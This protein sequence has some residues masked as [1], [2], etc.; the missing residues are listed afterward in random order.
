MKKTICNPSN[1]GAET[2]ISL[3]AQSH[4]DAYGRVSNKFIETLLGEQFGYQVVPAMKFL[5]DNAEPS[6][7]A[8]FVG[9]Y[10]TP[11]SLTSRSKA[12]VVV[13]QTPDKVKRTGNMG[14]YA[15]FIRHHDGEEQLVR[16][17]NQAS[18]IYYLMYLIDRRQNTG[19][20]DALS[21]HRNETPFK[22]LYRMVYDRVND[23]VLDC[24]YQSLLRRK[25]DNHYR[26]GRQNAIILDIRKH[27]GQLFAACGENYQPFAMTAHTHLSITPDHIVFDGDADRLLDLHFQ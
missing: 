3:Y 15:L 7:L 24:R 10:L 27:L 2:F 5:L 18:T 14:S 21:L 20:L 16:F 26:V 4:E 11:R 12:R 17:T 22:Q 6:V 23:D 19:E 8:R 25:V 13:R 1:I 9:D